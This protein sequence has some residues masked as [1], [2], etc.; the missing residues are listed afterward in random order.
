MTSP[1]DPRLPALAKVGL[2]FPGLT[3][4]ATSAQMRR[5]QRN[6][7]LQLY[8]PEESMVYTS[9]IELQVRPSVE[10]TSAELQS[11]RDPWFWTP[12]MYFCAPMDPAWWDGSALRMP[13]LEIYQY[14]ETKTSGVWN[15]QYIDYMVNFNVLHF[16]RQ[17]SSSMRVFAFGRFTSV[18]AS[19]SIMAQLPYFTVGGQPLVRRTSGHKRY[20]HLVL[21]GNANFIQ[22]NGGCAGGGGGGGCGC[23]GELLL[24]GASG[25][26]AQS[27]SEALKH[28]A[29]GGIAVFT[30][31]ASV[32]AEVTD[33]AEQ[34]SCVGFDPHL[35]CQWVFCES[36]LSI[37]EDV[38]SGSLRGY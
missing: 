26:Y 19:V 24:S 21:Q 35:S 14:F 37:F 1:G 16:S 32:F 3:E 31:S 22:P 10:L 36:H 5:L 12:W 25:D 34:W 20:M 27:V 15:R 18:Q 33:G 7:V 30:S 2:L 28:L 9:L 4:P 11:Q 13:Q 23:G 6:D 29:D 17:T 38:Q 8:T